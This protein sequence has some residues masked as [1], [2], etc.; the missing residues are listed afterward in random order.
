MPKLKYQTNL[1]VQAIT[2]HFQDGE[3]LSSICA[4]LRVPPVVCEQWCK[5]VISG[6]PSFFA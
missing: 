2:R 1:K 4:D 6:L 5:D 3:P